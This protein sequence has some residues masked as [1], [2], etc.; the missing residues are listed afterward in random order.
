MRLI[1]FRR[2]SVRAGVF[3]QRVIIDHV[4]RREIAMRDPF[5]ARKLGD[6]V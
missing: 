4:D 1:L 6:V 2:D 5:L 3:D